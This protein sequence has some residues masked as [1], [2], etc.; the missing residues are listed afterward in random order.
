MQM[1]TLA[2]VYSATPQTRVIR[3]I[4]DVPASLVKAVQPYT[5]L[6]T[7]VLAAWAPRNQGMIVIKGTTG[8]DQA[9]LVR[10][11]GDKPVQLTTGSDPVAN[12]VADPSGGDSFVFTRSPAGN[13]VDQLYRFDLD[14]R[15][16][17]LLTDGK[18]RHSRALWNRATGLIAYGR[19]VQ[20]GLKFIS[21]LRTMDPHQPAT[22][23]VVQ[24]LEGTNWSLQDWS[25]TGD[26]ALVIQR[27]DPLHSK[28][29]IVDMADGKMTLVPETSGGQPDYS[30]ARFAPDGR[31]LYVLSDRNSE[32]HQLGRLE[33]GTGQ[34]VLLT[35]SIKWD[36][37]G[38]AIARDGSRMAL[39]ANE[40]GN[41]VLYTMKLNAGRPKRVSQLAPGIPYSLRWQSDTRRLGFGFVSNR[42]TD[43]AFSYDDEKSKL[44]RWTKSYSPVSTEDLP[45]AKLIHWKS[46]DGLE[47]SGFLYAPARKFKGRRPV[48]IDIHGGPNAQARP[49]FITTGNYVLKELGVAYLFPNVRGSTG[50]GRTFQGLDDG[51]KRFDSVRD[52]GALL[53]WIRTQPTLD[54]NRV[55]VSGLSHGGYLS[56]SVAAFYSDR[57][58]CAVDLAG[59]SSLVTFIETTSAYRRD[60]QRTEYRDERIPEVRVV[61]EKISPLSNAD[62][63]RRPLLV[64][65]GE[66]D[67]RVPTSE[68]EQ[69]VKAVDS[70]GVPVW[71]LL[72]KDEGHVFSKQENV[73][74][75]LYVSLMF[76]Q[77][78]LLGQSS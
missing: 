58:R 40:N 66:N 4:P 75:Q 57:I 63:I 41:G 44:V 10:A 70:N 60:A 1:I 19:V 73:D 74:Y 15:A 23:R 46:F 54:P 38:F 59:P 69:I 43:D 64:V 53:D 51:V 20:E 29:W 18:S 77:R 42:S 61:L 50:F 35:G 52:L 5:V 3:G 32:F 28:L 31:A 9:Y 62:K 33:L 56:L 16:T 36:I 55:M 67:P 14:T 7:S 27:L 26:R 78:F 12:I 45:P 2:L 21:E 30:F 76:I 22:A 34:H 37:D 24:R 72:A 48:I 68:A 11:P 49:G 71:Y 39:V 13:E 8:V 25:P 17:T 47:L 6:D 65:Q